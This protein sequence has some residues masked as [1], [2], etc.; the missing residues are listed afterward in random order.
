MAEQY[1]LSFCSVTFVTPC[2]G[3]PDVEAASLHSVFGHF[4][5]K[6]GQL[7]QHNSTK[8][9][10]GKFPH[11]KKYQGS[12][13]KR[14]HLDIPSRYL[15]KK[16]KG[17]IRSFPRDLYELFLPGEFLRKSEADHGSIYKS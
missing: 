8:L 17:K 4:Q 14:N 1:K 5:D 13:Q 10:A 11:K 12:S 2:V 7:E 3:T 6:Q 9:S 16:N 15:K